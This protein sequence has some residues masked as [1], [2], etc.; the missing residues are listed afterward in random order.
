MGFPHTEIKNLRNTINFLTIQHHCYDR[1]VFPLL[2]IQELYQGM[3]IWIRNLTHISAERKYWEQNPK[4]DAI[5]WWQ[6]VHDICTCCSNRMYRWQ[7]CMMVKSHFLWLLLHQSWNYWLDTAK[8]QSNVVCQEA[9]D[10][11]GYDAVLQCGSR[12]CWGK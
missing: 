2:S 9:S 8:Q 4:K 7:S 12:L 10:L 6:H 3:H 11:L 5:I 1:I